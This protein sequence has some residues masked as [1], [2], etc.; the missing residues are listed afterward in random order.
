MTEKRATDDRRT[1]ARQAQ[2]GRIMWRKAGDH[3]TFAGWLSDLSP[4]SVSFVASARVQPTAGDEIEVIDPDR[5]RHAYRV[6]R[7]APYDARLALVA[8][9]STAPRITAAPGVPAA[10][11]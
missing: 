4:S 9:R 8:C 3:A 2:A 6:T 1:Q 11:V 7:I 5:S 10:E